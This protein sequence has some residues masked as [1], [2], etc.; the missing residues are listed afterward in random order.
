MTEIRNRTVR[1]GLDYD[2]NSIFAQPPIW[3]RFPI[4]ILLRK[5]PKSSY[6]DLTYTKV[7]TI[8]G[9]GQP[10]GESSV[11]ELSA[12]SDDHFSRRK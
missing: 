7:W 9:G 11:L 6:T 10:P 8:Y 3:G 4:Q 5:V 12:S 1:K 2:I